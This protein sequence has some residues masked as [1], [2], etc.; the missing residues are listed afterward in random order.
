MTDGDDGIVLRT[1]A[2][3]AADHLIAEEYER[4]KNTWREVVR[5]IAIAHV[6]SVV[7]AADSCEQKVLRDYAAKGDSELIRGESSEWPRLEKERDKALKRIAWLDCGG[8]LVFDQC[9]AM[10][11]VDVNS[12]KYTGKKLTAETLLTLNLQA[13]EE[14]A[15]QLRLR[16]I[17][18]VIIVDFV[19]MDSDDQRELIVQHLQQSL[20]KDRAKCVVHGF[21]SLGLLEMTR[22]RS[23]IPLRDNWTVACPHC[24]GIGRIGKEE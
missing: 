10:T 11:V 1:S 2:G 9:E 13:C 22:K 12:G 14:L 8:N 19:D 17:G 21:T 16:N 7:Y 24:G 23:G 4:L 20:Q 5:N 18:G 15:R 6:P 3:Q